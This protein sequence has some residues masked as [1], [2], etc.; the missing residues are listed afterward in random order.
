MIE[1]NKSD[2]INGITL[3]CQD[4]RV[5]CEN[6]ES[7]ALKSREQDAPELKVSLAC[8]R[9]RECP[10]AIRV[11]HP[12]CKQNDSYMSHA[13]LPLSLSLS[14]HLSTILIN[15]NTSLRPCI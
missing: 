7:T 9:E 3:T 2:E 12:L 8:T 11:S 4:E 5:S 14:L 1:I 6:P 15:N 13:S 10:L